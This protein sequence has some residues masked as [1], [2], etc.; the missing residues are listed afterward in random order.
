MIKPWPQNVPRSMRNLPDV[1]VLCGGAGVRLRSVTGDAPKVMARVAGRPFLEYPLR[2]VHRLGFSRVILAVGYQSEMIRSY[3]S[4]EIWGL[5]IAYSEENAPLGTGGALREAAELMKS[6]ITLVMNGDSYTDLDLGRFIEEH[7]TANVDVSVAVVPA[8]G[9]LDCGSVFTDESGRIIGF[10][11]KQSDFRSQYI[12]AGV[13]LL[14]KSLL[15][16]IPPGLQVSLERE[17][18]PSWLEAKRSIRAFFG[19]GR[20]VD[21]GTPER[22]REAQKIL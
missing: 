14:S 20:C 18:L 11:E 17:L 9:R 22:F 5:H 3:F 15:F 19:G 10:A 12:N 4:N 7:R 16:Q 2:Q 1:V 8:D 6:D 21:I 13:Y